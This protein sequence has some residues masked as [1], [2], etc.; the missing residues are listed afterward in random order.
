MG[1]LDVYRM[2]TARICFIGYTKK[3]LVIWNKTQ[4]NDAQWER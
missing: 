3:Q 4:F 2:E 1:R